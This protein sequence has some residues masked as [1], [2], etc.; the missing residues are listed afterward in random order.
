MEKENIKR[1]TPVKMQSF[2]LACFSFVS[3]FTSLAEAASATDIHRS[4]CR[5][6]T[7]MKATDRDKKLTGTASNI[8]S[9]LHEKRLSHC[10]MKCVRHYRCV[11][12]NY[13]KSFTGEQEKNCELLEVNKKSS[14]VTLSNENGWIHYEPVTQVS[15]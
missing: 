7:L 2:L 15:T 11:S 4:E 9:Q 3:L 1:K 10:I 6:D 8:I 14:S 13:K 5:R 12:A